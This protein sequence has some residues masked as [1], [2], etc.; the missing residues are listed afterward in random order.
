MSAKL[1]ELAAA[2]DAL[3]ADEKEEIAQPMRRLLRSP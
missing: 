1:K 2:F 3:S